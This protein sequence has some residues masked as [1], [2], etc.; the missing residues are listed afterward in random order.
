ME[1][2]LEGVTVP[3]TDVDRA[4]QCYAEQ[5]GFALD[6][7]MVVGNGVRL[8]QLTPPGSGC[9]IQFNTGITS[10]PPGT[11]D[12]LLLVVAD[13]DAARAELVAR[14]VDATPVRHFERGKWV[15]GR[16]GDWNSFVHF[17]DPDGN[18]WAVQERPAGA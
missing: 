13:I 15:E 1:W 10:P 12:G 8:V 16:G 3:V 5:A 2:K 11:L 14:G 7:D 18:G 17:R 9:S 6:L 4:K